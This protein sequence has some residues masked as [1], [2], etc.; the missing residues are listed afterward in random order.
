MKNIFL[1][2]ATIWLLLGC[3]STK[4]TSTI[5]SNSTIVSNQVEK[6]GSS[7]ENAIF[8]GEKTETKGVAEEYAWLREHYPGYVSK[9]QTLS[10]HKNKPYD[11]IRIVTQNGEEKSIYFDI[12]N[13]FGKY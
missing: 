7:F 3:S 8:I 11:I 12:S 9:G 6:N 10:E 4:H 5:F 1:F 13:F 2:L